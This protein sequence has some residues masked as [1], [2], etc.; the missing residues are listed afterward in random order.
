[1]L[2][3]NLPKTQPFCSKYPSIIA[4]QFAN[5]IIYGSGLKETLL[6][7]LK[8]ACRAGVWKALEFA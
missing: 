5:C 7:S 1:M 8:V 4:Y 3:S 2:F 6:N